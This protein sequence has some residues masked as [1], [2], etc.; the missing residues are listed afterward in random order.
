MYACREGSTAAVQ[1]TKAEVA[2]PLPPM[3]TPKR[4]AASAASLDVPGEYIPRLLRVCMYMP[5]GSL[6]RRGSSG[7]ASAGLR[8]A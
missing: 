2:R 6:D 1:P 7:A 8:F 5:T 3:P 4:D